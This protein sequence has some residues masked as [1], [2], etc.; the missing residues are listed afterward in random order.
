MSRLTVGYHGTTRQI[1]DEIVHGSKPFL[2]SNNEGDW[3]GYGA[4]FFEDGR[5]R[6]LTWAKNRY[7]TPLNEPAVVSVN[8]DLDGCLDLVDSKFCALLRNK[9]HDFLDLERQLG[10][11]DDQAGLIVL[12]GKVFTTE[13]SDT[14]PR[15]RPPIDNYRDRTF[16]NWIVRILRKRGVTIRSVR[17]VFLSGSGIFETSHV[18]DWGHIQIAVLDDTVLSDPKIV[19]I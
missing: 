18:F 2:K 10:S 14:N 19:E 4:Y 13:S 1:A 11:F 16:I 5:K 6:A 3:L 15:T 17:G 7:S 9:Y 8:I 12:G